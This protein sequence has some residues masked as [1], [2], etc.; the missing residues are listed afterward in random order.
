MR[1]QKKRERERKETR[2]INSDIIG[3]G[4]LI[5]SRKYCLEQTKLTETETNQFS[6][7]AP[8]RK[9]QI[10]ILEVP[11]SLPINNDCVV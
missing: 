1:N 9:I 6:T 3:K 5:L 2:V 11:L 7:N 8:S 4:N 10:L